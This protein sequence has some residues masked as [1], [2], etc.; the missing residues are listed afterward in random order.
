VLHAGPENH[1]IALLFQKDGLDL[2]VCA[3]PKLDLEF[4][5]NQHG[6][7]RC[8]VAHRPS[9]SRRTGIVMRQLYFGIK[10]VT[11][12][13]YEVTD[14]PSGVCY[15]VEVTVFKDRHTDLCRLQNFSRRALDEPGRDLAEFFLR[16]LFLGKRL[17][18]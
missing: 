7:R 9:L 14:V 8:D 1:I 2:G 10:R 17:L 3:C 12:P 16:R 11:W 15:A 6:Q 13:G 5:R 18:Q 4:A